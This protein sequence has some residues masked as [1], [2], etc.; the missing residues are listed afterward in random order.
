M[1]TV[2]LATKRGQFSQ[3]GR[4]PLIDHLPEFLLDSLAELTESGAYCVK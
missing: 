1:N 2:L 4:L 3:T